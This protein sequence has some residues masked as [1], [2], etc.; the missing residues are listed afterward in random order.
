M[1]IPWEFHEN[2]NS[3]WVTNGNGMGMGITSWEWNGTYK[4]PV[5]HSNIQ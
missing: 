2:R 1:G 4:R 5:L 3:F